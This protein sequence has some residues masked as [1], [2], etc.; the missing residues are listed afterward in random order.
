M[1]LIFAA[2]TALLIAGCIVPLGD[3]GG[4]RYERH[5]HHW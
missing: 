1:R 2:L 3:D 4:H 5:H